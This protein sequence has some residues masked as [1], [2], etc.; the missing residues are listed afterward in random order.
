MMGTKI[1]YCNYLRDWG[2]VGDGRWV[3]QEVRHEERVTVNLS[4]SNA[5]LIMASKKASQGED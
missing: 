1:G 3:Y 5:L 2:L 4:G